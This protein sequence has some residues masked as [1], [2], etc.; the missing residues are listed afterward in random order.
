MSDP[1]PSFAPFDRALHRRRLDRAASGFS[2]VGFLKTRAAMDAVER[3]EAILREFPVAVDLGDEEQILLCCRS[4]R[5][6]TPSRSP[7]N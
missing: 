3:L 6:S 1:S 4:A 7:A 5:C 2:A